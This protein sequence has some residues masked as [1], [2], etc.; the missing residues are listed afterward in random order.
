MSDKITRIMKEH[1]KIAEKYIDDLK[2]ADTKAGY[3]SAMNSCA[4]SIKKQ[5]PDLE[6]ISDEFNTLMVT[7]QASEEIKNASMTAG[8]CFGI[9]SV[10]IYPRMAPHMGDEDFRAAQMNLDG[11]LNANPLFGGQMGDDKALNEVSHTFA[12]AMNSMAEK[13][14]LE[15]AEADT[16]AIGEIETIMTEFDS[17]AKRFAAAVE[18]ADT[19]RKFVTAVDGFVN[20]VNKMIPRMKELSE[21]MK[22][23]MAQKLLPEKIKEI[24]GSIGQTLGKDLTEILKD[25][26]ELM[27][28]PKV[29][30]AVS[31]LGSMLESIPF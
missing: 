30:K 28:E 31:K 17:L 12:S 6:S 5:Y 22:V 29:K 25:K 24:S 2:K 11:V 3:I 20:A 21:P 14:H 13:L 9:R 15:T 10:E 8:A 27:A 1:Q 4:D 7:N 23:L 19:S 18:K 26:R 16:S